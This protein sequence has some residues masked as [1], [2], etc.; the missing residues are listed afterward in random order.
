VAID[1]FTTAQLNRVVRQIDVDPAAWLLTSFFPMEQVS[2]DEEIHFDVEDEQPRITPFVSPLRA[3]RLVEREG[4]ETRTFKPAYVKDKRVFDESAPVKRVMG[5]P[6][7]GTLSAAER[8]RRLLARA[9]ANQNRM[10]TRRE[11]VMASEILR[12]GS[13]TIT[14]EGFDD[15]VVNYLRDASLTVTPLTGAA[16]WS[17]TTATPM[18]DIEDWA[19]LIYTAGGGIA[20]DVVMAPDVWQAMRKNSQVVDLLDTRRGSESRAETGPLA[21]NRVRMPGSL[22]EFDLWV[23]QDNYIDETGAAGVMMPS[24][25]VLLINRTGLEG[26]RH[27]GMVKDYKAMHTAQ[28]WFV[29]S[30]EEEDPSRRILLGQAAPLVVPYRPNSSLGAEVLNGGA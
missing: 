11:E 5:E 6:P 12:T 15:V 22:G 8:T 9:F 16:R 4:Y 1:L 27:Y 24:G 19:Q 17:E 18:D 29:K 20:R 3:G 10:F 30:W 7:L 21:A 26:T 13:L 2:E 23:Y 28:R 14:G 25:T